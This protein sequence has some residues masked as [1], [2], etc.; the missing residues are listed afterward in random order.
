MIALFLY[1]MGLVMFTSMTKKIVDLN[2]GMRRFKEQK[3]FLPRAVVAIGWPI[4]MAYILV[5]MTW[6]KMTGR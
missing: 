5:S 1:L 3:Y 4:S 6:E 2:P